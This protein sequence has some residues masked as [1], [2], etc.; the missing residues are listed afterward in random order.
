MTLKQNVTG[1]FNRDDLG[2]L[3]SAIAWGPLT[4]SD[5]VE[6]AKTEAAQQAEEAD[7]RELVQ[8]GQRSIDSVPHASAVTIEAGE[9]QQIVVELPPSVTT[10]AYEPDLRRL[11]FMSRSAWAL[12]VDAARAAMKIDPTADDGRPAPTPDDYANAKFLRGNLDGVTAA[13]PELPRVDQIL[14]EVSE[15]IL[16]LG[17]K[18][19]TALY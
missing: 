19:T 7:L 9:I 2:A 5:P 15:E 8:R 10:L 1:K 4:S 17:A 14:A 11:S 3:T 16:R 6:R 12:A 18:G 13:C